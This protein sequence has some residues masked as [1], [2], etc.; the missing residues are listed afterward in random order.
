MAQMNCLER[1]AHLDIGQP[2]LEGV[3]VHQVGWRSLLVGL[4]ECAPFLWIQEVQDAEAPT[5]PA[6]RSEYYAGFG[7]K[8]RRV[9]VRLATFVKTPA[10]GKQPNTTR[11]SP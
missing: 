1:P 11:T 6:Y 2:V 9:D 5:F 7:C 8:I 10:Q 4:A 3:Q